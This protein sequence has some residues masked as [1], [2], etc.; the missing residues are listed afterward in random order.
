MKRKHLSLATIVLIMMTLLMPA[1]TGCRVQKNEFA[2]KKWKI[3]KDHPPTQR[4]YSK[5]NL[6]RKH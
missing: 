4:Y 6:F 2:K 3:H 1:M 5:G